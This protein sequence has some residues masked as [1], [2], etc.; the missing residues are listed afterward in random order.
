MSLLSLFVYLHFCAILENIS[1]LSYE[2]HNIAF[3]PLLPDFAGLF[4][5]SLRIGKLLAQKMFMG[6]LLAQ[7][8]HFSVCLG[9]DFNQKETRCFRFL[10]KTTI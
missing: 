5:L 10:D 6:R 1:L 7:G 3:V 8:E 4:L 9:E 2:M